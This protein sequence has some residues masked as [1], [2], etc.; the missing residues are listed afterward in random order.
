MA[1]WKATLHKIFA[2]PGLFFRGGKS[3]QQACEYMTLE[4][5]R[6]SEWNSG[7]LLEIPRSKHDKVHNFVRGGN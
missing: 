3:W 1:V 2:I 6:G 4:P 5:Y 7:G